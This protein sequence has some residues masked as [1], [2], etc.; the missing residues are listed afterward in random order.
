VIEPDYVA[1]NREQ[2][3]RANAEYTD[4]AAHDAWAREEVTWGTWHEPERELRLLPDLAG[5]DVVE[6]GCGTAYFGAWLKKAGARRVVGVDVTPAQLETARRMDEEF[7]LGLEFL[8]E[9]AERTSLPDDSFDL[10]VSEYGASIW[11]DTRKWIAEAARLLRPRGELIFLRGSTLRNLCTPD[12]GVATDR[13]VFPQKGMYRFD[14]QEGD[15][16]GT[17]FHPPTMEMFQI[18]REKGFELLDFRELYAP[19]DAEDHPYYV[20]LPAQW[21][22]KWPAEEVWRARLGD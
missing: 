14:W 15:E 22:K 9:N 4:A 17:E 18:L 3:T 7:G 1:V 16:A 12:E 19:D 21:A 11:C 6:L 2:W 20:H 10:V 5:K 13:L 8:E